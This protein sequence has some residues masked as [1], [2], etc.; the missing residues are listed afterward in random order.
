MET[1]RSLP[2]S[3]VP[4]TCPNPESDQSSPWPPDYYLKI[5][6]NFILPSKPG[7]PKWSLSLR[8]PHQNPV[9]LSPLPHTCYMLRPYYSSRFYWCLK[10]ANYDTDRSDIIFSSLLYC[11]F[12]NN[13]GIHFFVCLL[14]LWLFH[15]CL[16]HCPLLFVPVMSCPFR[17]W[18]F[19]C[20]FCTSTMKFFIIVKIVVKKS[21][22]W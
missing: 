10:K 16:V 14:C 3:Q 2:Q 17:N 18:P 6:L 15:L 22:G 8:F 5:H 13:F 21:F 20:W 9:Y 19:G 4:S 1:E 7:S 11:T 12:I